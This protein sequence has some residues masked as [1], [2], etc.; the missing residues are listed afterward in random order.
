MKKRILKSKLV[1][2]KKTV[3]NFNVDAAKGGTGNTF[4]CGPSNNPM[5]TFD[6]A[7]FSK[8][9]GCSRWQVC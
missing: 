8:G 4:H 9:P 1:I 6:D 2:S 3:S 7:C 5:C